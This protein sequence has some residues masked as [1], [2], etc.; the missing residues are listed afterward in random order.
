MVLDEPKPSDQI[1]TQEQAEHKVSILVDPTTDIYL[2]PHMTL[3]YD[4]AVREFQLRSKNSA[5]PYRMRL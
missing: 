5:L 4:S 1:F 2:D 3:D